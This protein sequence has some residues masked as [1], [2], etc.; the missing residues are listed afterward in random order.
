MS[1]V[2]KE[3]DALPPNFETS[4]EYQEMTPDGQLAW[5]TY[6]AEKMHGLPL[7]VQIV[8]RRFE[9][10]KVLAAM[11]VVE[12]TLKNKGVIFKAKKDLI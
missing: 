12:Q 7:S 2:N 10:E 3:L 1:N 5:S 4:A 11:R 9:E 8:G 6:D